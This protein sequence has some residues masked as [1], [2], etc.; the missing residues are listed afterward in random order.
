MFTGIVESI[1][2]VESVQNEGDVV[3]LWVSTPLELIDTRLGDSIAVDG[4]CLTV[5]A[6]RAG[7]PSRVAFDI[8]PESL[9][10]TSLRRLR[11]GSRVHLERAL[12]LA[13]RLGGHLV[14]GHVDGVGEVRRATRQGETL[15]LEIGASP[16]VLRLCIHK[17]SICLDGVS[18]TLN[19]VKADAFGVW[20]IPHTLERTRL[21][22]LK[23]GD[24]INIENDVVG[25]YIE[26]LL[27]GHEGGPRGV[28][29][30]LL[31]SN[32]FLPQPAP[33]R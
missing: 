18:L 14:Q 23:A 25:K 21:G 33:E 22:E 28:T 11:N 13:D 24:V 7:A 1:G 12:R 2:T 26:K 3:R 30:E 16:E 27:Q 9:R 19:E 17:G 31:A 4:V 6:L 8:G 15:Q 10:V 29:W 5:T 32:G 20:L